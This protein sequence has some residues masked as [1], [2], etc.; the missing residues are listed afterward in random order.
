MC[1]LTNFEN[2]PEQF[3]HRTPP[4]DDSAGLNRH[5]GVFCER[6]ILEYFPVAT[7]SERAVLKYIS[8]A[9]QTSP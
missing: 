2:I 4:H 6:A 8:V 7:V 1:F 3:F 5:E 9:G